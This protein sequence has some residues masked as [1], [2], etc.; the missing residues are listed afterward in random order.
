VGSE[1]NPETKTIAIEMRGFRAKRVRTE[2]KPRARRITK[3][4]WRKAEAVRLALSCLHAQSGVAGSPRA[5]R[6]RGALVATQ[7]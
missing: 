1:G 2:L 4:V 6:M 5:E 3:R 7:A